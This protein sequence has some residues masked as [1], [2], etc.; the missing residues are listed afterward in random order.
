MNLFILL[1]YNAKNGILN[2]KNLEV[3]EYILIAGF[4]TVTIVY[5]G[6][7]PTKTV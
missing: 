1:D 4:E 6:K 5:K 7:L 3:S 2:V